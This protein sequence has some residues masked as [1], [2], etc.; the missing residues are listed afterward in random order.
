[1]QGVAYGAPQQ[2]PYGMPPV[3]GQPYGR[4]YPPNVPSY[5]APQQGKRDT[6][7]GRG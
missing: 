5:G 4:G 3:Y 7:G 1:M 6:P 2:Q